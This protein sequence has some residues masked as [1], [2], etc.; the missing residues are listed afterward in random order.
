VDSKAGKC[1]RCV[2]KWLGRQIERSP[3]M[4]VKGSSQLNVKEWQFMSEQVSKALDGDTQNYVLYYLISMLLE[5]N[6]S[7]E[8]GREILYAKLV[9]QDSVR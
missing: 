6:I 9:N 3:S 8:D 5:L 7:N 1:C 2:L 4:D